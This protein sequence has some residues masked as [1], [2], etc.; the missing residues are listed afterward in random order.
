MDCFFFQNKGPSKRF[1]CKIKLIT[2][3][4]ILLF[5]VELNFSLPKRSILTR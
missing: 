4:R 5:E 2:L 1:E 3:E